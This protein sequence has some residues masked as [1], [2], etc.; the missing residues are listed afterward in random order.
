MGYVKD[1]RKT[2][3]ETGKIF[4]SLGVVSLICINDNSEP[5]DSCHL[6]EA[7]SWKSATICSNNPCFYRRQALPPPL[8]ALLS[9]C[10]QILG[11]VCALTGQTGGGPQRQTCLASGQQPE[12][13]ESG[14]PA[15]QPH[16]EPG[17]RVLS[18]VGQKGPHG[19]TGS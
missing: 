14:L 6:R 19:N 3:R 8:Q 18:K 13:A 12:G 15:D 2:R 1:R 16:R 11:E 10:S 4:S 7:G 17:G 9:Q 5:L